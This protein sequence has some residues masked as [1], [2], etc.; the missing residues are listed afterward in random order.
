M[1]SPIL[2]LWGKVNLSSGFY[3]STILT[4][5]VNPQKETKCRG[6]TAL[7]REG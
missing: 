3:S 1:G 6:G 5:C 7:D 4:L 2:T